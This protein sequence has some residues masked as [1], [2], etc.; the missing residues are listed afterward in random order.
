MN[1]LRKYTD[2]ELEALERAAQRYRWLREQHWS[3]GKVTI[4][5]PGS[6][7]LGHDTFS[8]GRLDLVIDEALS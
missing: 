4:T 1:I 5:R 7:E 3:D 8:G 2:S 6:V